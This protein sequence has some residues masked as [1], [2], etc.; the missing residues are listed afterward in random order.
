MHVHWEEARALSRGRAN[1]TGGP[2][3]QPAS[4]TWQAPPWARWRAHPGLAE[5]LQVQLCAHQGLASHQRSHLQPCAFCD[6]Q[7]QLLLTESR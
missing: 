7:Q 3:P 5:G 6:Q 4:T 2:F 1:S